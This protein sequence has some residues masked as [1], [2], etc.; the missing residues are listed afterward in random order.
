MA[1]KFE[2]NWRLWIEEL[3]QRV[4]L[5]KPVSITRPKRQ[6]IA[7]SASMTKLQKP[8]RHM[9]F[10]KLKDGRFVIG[11]STL[12]SQQ[13]QI[14]TLLHEWA[15]CL[16]YPAQQ[17]NRTTWTHDDIFGLAFA[18]T[19]RQFFNEEDPNLDSRV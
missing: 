2:R 12:E 10:A 11:I 13:S 1:T 7:V 16:A 5:S 4:P 14:E 19:Y 8:D 6:I 3:K 18:F 17:A 9:G 15:H